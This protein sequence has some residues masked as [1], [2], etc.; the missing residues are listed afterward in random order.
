MI[1]ALSLLAFQDSLVKLASSDVS[2]W[3]FQLLRSACNLAFLLI[4]SRFLWGGRIP[5]PKSWLAVGLRSLFLVGAMVFFFGGIPFL[6]LSEIAAGLYVFPLFIA[7]LSVAVLGEKV[8][9]RRVFAI[10]AGFTGTLLIL[11]PGSEAF[12]WVGLMPVAAGLSYAATV[13]T[14]RKLCREENPATLALG[15]SVGFLALGAAGLLG[16]SFT[17]DGELAAAWPYL[18]TSWHELTLYL[19]GIVVACSTLNLT[20]NIALAKAYQSAE[21]SWLAPFDYSYL[22]FATFWGFVMWGDLPDGLSV[23]G[24]SL[25]AGAGCYVAWR[26]ARAG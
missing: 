5:L 17:A 24:M 19:A 20:A 22:I 6:S 1:F 21:S 11:K 25:I 2:L 16:T 10:L 4:L 23:L 3:Q 15:V 14:T 18:F 8:G 9:P 7:L 12:Q 26:E 13:L